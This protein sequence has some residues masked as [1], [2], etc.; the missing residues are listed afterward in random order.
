[1]Q[2]TAKSKN[3]F[4]KPQPAI[5]AEIKSEFQKSL[6]LMPDFGPAHELLG[7]LLMIEDEDLAA[8]EKHLQRAIELEPENQSY[9][10]SLAQLQWRRN[11]VEA[12]RHTLEPLLV[13]Y[14]DPKLRAHAEQLLREMGEPGK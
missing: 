3:V 2:S 5:A 9:L 11:N 6:A 12:A 4:T 8:A 14:A 13:S 7:F 10:F 1:M